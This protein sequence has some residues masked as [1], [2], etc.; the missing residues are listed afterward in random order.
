MVVRSRMKGQYMCTLEFINKKKN[1]G[2]WLSSK[3]L[4]DSN[5][6]IVEPEF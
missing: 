4:A 6:S 1:T 2:I 3:F 5:M